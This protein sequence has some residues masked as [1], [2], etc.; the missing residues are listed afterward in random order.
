MEALHMVVLVAMGTAQQ[1]RREPAGI[2]TTAARGQ[3]FIAALPLNP[4][5]WPA[6]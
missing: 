4:T 6:L 5:T 2:I 1:G 3:Q